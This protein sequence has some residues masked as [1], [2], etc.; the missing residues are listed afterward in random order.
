MKTV[1]SYF[2]ASDNAEY[3]LLDQSTCRVRRGTVRATEDGAV[4]Y[5]VAPGAIAMAAAAGARAVATQPGSLALAIVMG[6]QAAAS[7][8]HAYAQAWAVGAIA[9]A[10]SPGSVA[11]ASCGKAV[12]HAPGAFVL[13]SG[14]AVLDR[15]SAACEGVIAIALE[16]LHQSGVEVPPVPAVATRIPGDCG[17]LGYIIQHDFYRAESREL[18]MECCY[19][20]INDYK[21]LSDIQGF[22]IAMSGE[23]IHKSAAYAGPGMHLRDAIRHAEILGDNVPPAAYEKLQGY[24]AKQNQAL[25]TRAAAEADNTPTL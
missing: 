3:T 20:W 5:A 10:F 21:H 22:S 2:E 15:Y 11:Q 17:D 7:A 1:N 12:G 24:V 16:N 25:S 6:A 19:P 23:Q 4:V 9:E 13:S 14:T 18:A 8:R